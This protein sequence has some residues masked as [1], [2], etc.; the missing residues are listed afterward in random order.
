M[1]PKFAFDDPDEERKNI[2]A[3]LM[4]DHY[5]PPGFIN[6]NLI[7]DKTLEQYNTHDT[8]KW[9]EYFKEQEKAYRTKNIIV[10]WGDD[11]T[12]YREDGGTLENA[13]KIVEGLNAASEG[14][15]I[16]KHSTMKN[17]FDSVHQESKEKSIEYDVATKDF[18]RLNHW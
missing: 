13:V 12:H 6:K 8:A 16:V 5:T 7:N 18:W 17:Y 11:L 10:M 3:H 14:K 4:F 1:Q 15:F 2:F 9:I